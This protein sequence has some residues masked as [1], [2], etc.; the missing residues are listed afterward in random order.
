MERWAIRAFPSA[1]IRTGKRVRCLS[2]LFGD[3]ISPE[4]I[5]K[6]FVWSGAEEAPSGHDIIEWFEARGVTGMDGLIHEAISTA[7]KGEK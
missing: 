5:G 6:T 3:E 4:T 1:D 2:V 7:K